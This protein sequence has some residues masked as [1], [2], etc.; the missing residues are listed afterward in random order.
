MKKVSLLFLLISLFT[1]ISIS[2]SYAF[3]V[4]KPETNNKQISFKN[5]SVSEYINLSARQFSELTG[6]K[7]NLWNRLSFNLMKVKM[8]YEIKKNPN[9][10]VKEFIKDKPK[11]RLG[12]V[13]W[14]LIG[15]AGLF[16]ILLLIVAIACGNTLC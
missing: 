2:N 7:M 1:T 9:L 10:T 4:H 11:H 15:A 12:A 16:L 5:L 13:W 14:I 6:K 3:S 8:R